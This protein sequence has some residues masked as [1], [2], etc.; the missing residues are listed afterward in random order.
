[1]PRS[2]YAGLSIQSTNHKEA[3]AMTVNIRLAQAQDYPQWL[4]LWEGYQAF[5]KTTVAE[6]VTRQTW[7]RFLD[8][9]E[10]I[11]CAVAEQDG[12]LLGLTHYIFHRSSSSV[13]D[14]VYLQDL[15]A[16]PARRGQGIGRA[17]IEHVYGAAQAQGSK[18]VWWQTHETNTTAMQL[19]DKV[20][21]KPEFVQ[22]R[23]LMA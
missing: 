5:Y 16:A 12:Q 18:R 19:Y 21:D 4:A 23:K 22:Y 20:A 1:M 7:A 8:P 2:A 15:F 3:E 17:L 6:A 14:A 13:A 10:P 11:H 9:A